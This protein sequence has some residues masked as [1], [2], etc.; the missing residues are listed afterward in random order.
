[1]EIDFYI[2]FWEGLVFFCFN[3][4]CNPFKMQL[5]ISNSSDFD[6]NVCTLLFKFFKMLSCFLFNFSSKYASADNLV[7]SLF[8]SSPAYHWHTPRHL[9]PHDL[10]VSLTPILSVQWA[11]HAAQSK[12]RT[13]C[14][15]PAYDQVNTGVALGA[16][17][18]CAPFCCSSVSPRVLSSQRSQ[19]TFPSIQNVFRFIWSFC[20]KASKYILI[21]IQAD[22]S[23]RCL[24]KN[25]EAGGPLNLRT[26]LLQLKF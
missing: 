17:V 25:A 20:G 8:M 23:S 3:I 14:R 19:I 11:S 6:H 21:L 22:D 15:V 18:W 12:T 5:P 26:Q 24:P 13:K 10:S 16:C 7:S 1:M 4:L 2:L 9:M